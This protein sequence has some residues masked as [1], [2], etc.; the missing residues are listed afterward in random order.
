MTCHCRIQRDAACKCDPGTFA[1]P[2]VHDYWNLS[3]NTVGV[4]T[5]TESSEGSGAG[6]QS[7]RHS[8]LSEVILRNQGEANDTTFSSFLND[9]SKMLYH[10][11]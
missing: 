6:T 1:L 10:L 9:F 8:H 2:D 4:A 7:Q 11:K 3:G 5:D